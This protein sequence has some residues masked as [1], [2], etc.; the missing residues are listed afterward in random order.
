MNV[1]VHTTFPSETC[2]GRN[3]AR[4]KSHRGFAK[5]LRHWLT[6]WTATKW[7]DISLMWKG[8]AL[9]T[10][11]IS[12]L[13]A[14]AERVPLASGMAIAVLVGAA[15]I[16]VRERRLPNPIVL[17]A[18]VV[19]VTTLAVEISLGRS[20][21]S[22]HIAI[23]AAAMAGP[24][25][26]IHIVAPSSMGFGDVKTSIVLGA[27]VGAVDWSLALGALAVASAGTAFV[28]LALRQRTIA[29]GPGLVAGA[30][31][32]LALQGTILPPTE[33]IDSGTS[34]SSTRTTS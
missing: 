10:V 25:L 30:A 7:S 22:D 18:G 6:G 16:D 4:S 14:S 1:P 12:I 15:V 34:R 19:F 27:A 33:P 13:A 17:S 8:A 3:L 5:S 11:T 26:I 21:Q 24:L 31:L 28:G 32:V 2:G 20:V 23:G 29:F 9:L